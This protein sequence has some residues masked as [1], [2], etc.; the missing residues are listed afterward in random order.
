MAKI[1]EPLVEDLV[2]ADEDAMDVDEG[3]GK[4]SSKAREKILGGCVQ[5]LQQSFSPAAS[6]IPSSGEYLA[7][8]CDEFRPDSRQRSIQTAVDDSGHDCKIDIGP[9][10]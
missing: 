9:Q 5:A 10:Q 8:C 3:N 2:A 6:G 4:G 7:P 1:V